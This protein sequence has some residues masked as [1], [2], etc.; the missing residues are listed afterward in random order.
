[1][2]IRIRSVAAG[3]LALAVAVTLAG[4]GGG[5]KKQADTGVGDTEVATGGR[6]FST[7]DAATAK[8]GS[9]AQPGVFPRTVKHALGE[10]SQS[11]FAAAMQQALGAADGLADDVVTHYKLSLDGG[12]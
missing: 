7:A 12:S 10:T 5:D 3:T 2:K 6:L 1:M 9:D 8:L 4:C 11:P